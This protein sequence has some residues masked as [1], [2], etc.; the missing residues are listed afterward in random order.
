MPAFSLAVEDL[1]GNPFLSPAL[2]RV[3]VGKRGNLFAAFE[4]GAV[5][6]GAVVAEQDGARLRVR[7]LSRAD[8]NK[9]EKKGRKNRKF[10]EPIFA[11]LHRLATYCRFDC[12][13]C[14]AHPP[15]VAE[16]PAPAL[17]DGQACPV[18]VVATPCVA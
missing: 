1:F 9:D 6:A 12:D 15:A 14:T 4:I 18:T 8:R 17:G 10:H 11:G 16:D 2:R 13:D 3:E 7:R 5:T